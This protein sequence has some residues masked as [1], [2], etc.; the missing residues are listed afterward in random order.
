[1][2]LLEYPW[3]V[4]ILSSEWPAET[5]EGAAN[6]SYELLLSLGK[7]AFIAGCSLKKKTWI[8]SYIFMVNG[9]KLIKCKFPDQWLRKEVI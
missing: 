2:P 1:M 6:H 3:L 4:V 8:E 5:L 7:P 9:E